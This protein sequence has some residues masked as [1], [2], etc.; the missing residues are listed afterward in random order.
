[1]W[2]AIILLPA[3]LIMFGFCIENHEMKHSYVGVTVG[4]ALTCKSFLL[5]TCNLTKLILN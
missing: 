3:G 4:M 5:P 1:M 2:P